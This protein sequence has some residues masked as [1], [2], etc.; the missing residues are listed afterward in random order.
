[1]SADGGLAARD[2]D[3]PQLGMALDPGAIAEVVAA[4]RPE[5]GIA[6]AAATYVRYKPAT[7]A[8]VSYRFTSANGSLLGY[9]KTVRGGDESKIAK[10]VRAGGIGVNGGLAVNLFPVD[11][12]LRALQ[13]PNGSLARLVERLIPEADPGAQLHTLRYKPERR[14][15]AAVD[16]GGSHA[17]VIRAHTDA[18]YLWA[19]R[20][21]TAFTSND[22]FTVAG[23]VGRSDSKRALALQWMPGG[24]FSHSLGDA[25]A[26]QVGEALRWLHGTTPRARVRGDGRR[27]AVRS[28]VE[29]A[30]LTGWL[31]P[32]RAEELDRLTQRLV[33]L[34]GRSASQSV[35]THGDFSADQVLVDGGDHRIGIIDWDRAAIGDAGW[36]LGC[37]LADL[38]CRA[39]TG[40]VDRA[41][42]DRCRSALLEGYGDGP[43]TDTVPLLTQ[44]ALV[45][46]TAEPFRSRRPSWDGE[47]RAIVDRVAQL[48]P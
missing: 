25:L 28:M 6:A 21:A 10:M 42:V 13:S 32:D 20:A 24:P 23:V 5:L 26:S 36:D 11:R 39:V 15:V 43:G 34:M 38:E 29:T 2:R 4:S 35:P 17:A 27:R 41:T 9:A 45:A 18:D 22:R 33:G 1:M 14:Y 3:L 30:A 47:M 37:F 31:L 44:A 48:A 40:T 16:S 8:I 7:N 46:R 12:E 19:R